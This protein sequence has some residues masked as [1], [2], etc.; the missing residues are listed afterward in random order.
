MY[1][2][3]QVSLQNSEPTVIAIRIVFNKIG[4]IRGISI[5][6]GFRVWAKVFQKSPVRCASRAGFTSD[7][8]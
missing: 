4:H 1:E 8:G 7:Q 2:K 3:Q 5:Y 6:R